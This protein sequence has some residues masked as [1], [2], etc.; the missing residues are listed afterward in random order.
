MTDTTQ[1]ATVKVIVE[2]NLGWFK[3]YPDLGIEA[4]TSFY[5][6]YPPEK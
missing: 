3:T 2:L 6:D 1:A 5:S 4:L